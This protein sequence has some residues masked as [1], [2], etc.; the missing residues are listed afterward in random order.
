[1]NLAKLHVCDLM[2]HADELDESELKCLTFRRL[3]DLIMAFTFVFSSNSEKPFYGP[4][5][6]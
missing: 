3:G 4:I 1:M 5:N 6:C 2:T